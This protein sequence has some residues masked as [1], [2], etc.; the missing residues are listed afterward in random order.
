M[1]V[2]TLPTALHLSRFPRRALAIP[3]VLVALA[4]AAC[5]FWLIRDLPNPTALQ[6]RQPG[7]TTK[8]YDRYGTLL[9]EVVPEKGGKRSPLA[10]DRFPRALRL[11]TVATEDAAFF[12]NPGIDPRGI[13]RAAWSNL[14]AG[15]IVAGGS[16]I[17]QQ[18]VRQMLLS[19][20]ER[21]QRTLRRKLREAILALR[22]TR[23][24]SKDQILALYLNHTYYGHLAFGAEAAA[25]TYFGKHVWELDLAES[26]LLAGLPQAPGRYDPLTNL[27]AARRRQRDVLRLMVQNRFITPREAALA[28]GEPLHFTSTPFPIQAPHFVMY[29][30][31]ALEE[32]FGTEAL[33]YGG[34]QV[35][36]TL[37]LDLQEAAERTI[38]RQLE[39]LARRNDQ[40]RAHHVQDAALVAIKPQTGEILAMVGS[41]DYF[42]PEISGAVNAALA[43]RQPGS[44]IKPVTYAAAFDPGAGE[45]APYTPATVLNDVPTTFLTREGT[46]YQP[47]NYDRRFHGPLSLRDALATSNN[48]IAVKVLDHVGI[49]AMTRMARRLGITSWRHPERY[50]LALTLGGAEVSLVELTGV[51]ATFAA[52]GLHREPT[53]ILRVVQPKGD[54][55][56]AWRP[57]PGRRAVS[58]EVAYLISDILSDN[59]ARAP[60]FGE[61]S[62][63]R[64]S[65]PAAVKTGTTGDW[66]DNWTVGYTP[67]LT[68]GV[69][70]GNADGTPMYG[71]SGVDGAGPIWHDF[72]EEA[73]A[74]KPE[75][76][77][78]RPPGLVREEVCVALGLLPTPLCPQRRLEW[79][80]AGTEPTEYD[81]SYRVLQV[82]EVSG[83]LASPACPQHVVERVFRIYPPEAREWARRQGIPQPPEQT[84]DARRPEGP[85]LAQARQPAQERGIVITNPPP[86]AE[87]RLSP[88]LP[89]DAQRIPLSVRPAG[90]FRPTAV[91][92][93]LDDRAVAEFRQGPYRILWPLR[94]GEHVLRAVAVDAAGRRVEGDPVRFTV[95]VGP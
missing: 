5:W 51:Y 46:P 95:S 42:D 48:V 37:D 4:V 10:V 75:R 31:S 91:T 9:Y 62:V 43:L 21:R 72:M 8:I 70:V 81:D 17:T 26:A 56:Y 66:R 14:R 12:N 88:A 20:Q 53:A 54:V 69:W 34:L 13:V 35:T 63:L 87:F 18:V 19:P 39:R 82:D 28:A 92:L 80:V 32:R 58:A 57:D 94:A 64:L 16:T 23:T 38:R 52:G 84:C 68:V 45:G 73:L 59:L 27:P 86:N 85:P 29:V 33:L 41:P 76:A 77:F 40:G 25:Q 22:L 15:R 61:D 79:F 55:D 67:D 89:A 78:V 24:Y 44:A 50:G 74:G 2:R 3:L 47:Y 1:R 30:I 7:P 93:M 49:K 11:A 83:L 90:D 6:A 36:T 71:V 60:A 65:R